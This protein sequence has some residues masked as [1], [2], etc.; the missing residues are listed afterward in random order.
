M[1]LSKENKQEPITLFSAN[2][3]DT[4]RDVFKCPKCG[5]LFNNIE[6][7]KKC[8]HRKYI[9]REDI[10]KFATEDEKEFLKEGH[11]DYAPE[12]L[13][14]KLLLLKKD[15][16]KAKETLIKHHSRYGAHEMGVGSFADKVIGKL[17]DK[18]KVND[19]T[20]GGHFAEREMAKLLH[21][22]WTWAVNYTGEEKPEW[23]QRAGQMNI[24]NEIKKEESKELTDRP[25]WTVKGASFGKMP[26]DIKTEDIDK[27]ATEDEKK[28]LKEWDG[29]KVMDWKAYAAKLKDKTVAE[30]YYMRK[31]A[32]EAALAGDDLA[33]AGLPNNG[34]YYWDEVFMITDELRKRTKMMLKKPKVKKIPL[35]PEPEYGNNGEEIKDRPDYDPTRDTEFKESKQL[36]EKKYGSLYVSQQKI[37]DAFI[38]KNAGKVGLNFSIDDYP[39]LYDVIEAIHDAETLWQDINRYVHDNYDK[40]DKEEGLHT[41][42][43]GDSVDP[44][45]TDDDREGLMEAKDYEKILRRAMRRKGRQFDLGK[46]YSNSESDEEFHQKAKTSKYTPTEIKKFMKESVAEQKVANIIKYT[47]GDLDKWEAMME[48]MS[49]RELHDAE[50]ELKSAIAGINHNFKT[51]HV[52]QIQNEYWDELK[53]RRQLYRGYLNRLKKYREKNPRESLRDKEKEELFSRHV[54][55]GDHD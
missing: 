23:L 8:K 27:F 31:D 3:S 18:W 30:L 6:A 40:F 24:E 33:K 37:L 47:D 46:L 43:W 32:H 4:N 1:K 54:R 19:L 53:E 36:N 39:N 26:W 38:K 2:P 44:L 29:K 35:D 48:H 42:H 17:E 12:H 41:F 21:D 49:E 11:V 22:F 34:G 20:Y 10:D 15:I 45:M 25:K 50:F 16:A 5:H 52:R 14:S 55:G 9:K 7:A 13:K 28:I 51:Y